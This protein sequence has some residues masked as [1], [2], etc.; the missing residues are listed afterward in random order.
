MRTDL[1]LGI[2]KKKKL[3]KKRNN[4]SGDTCAPT[5][6]SLSHPEERPL[7]RGGFADPST[8]LAASR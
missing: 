1:Y 4:K 5:W 8:L 2:T 3:I 7:I 6:V